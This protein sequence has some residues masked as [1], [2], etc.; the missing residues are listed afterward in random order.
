LFFILPAVLDPDFNFQLMKISISK[1]LV[2]S[3]VTQS[4]PLPTKLETIDVEV[5]V[6]FWLS[7]DVFLM[8]GYVQKE[9]TL[10]FLNC[11]KEMRGEYYFL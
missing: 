1:P 9:E 2:T 4:N 7:L 8:K 3:S 6:L 11:E 5:L 10:G